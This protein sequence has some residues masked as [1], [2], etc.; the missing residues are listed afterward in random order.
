VSCGGLGWIRAIPK[1]R[2]DRRIGDLSAQHLQA[3]EN[4]LR[5]VL[6]LEWLDNG[7]GK[8]EL[9]FAGGAAD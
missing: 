8:A 2:L 7:T 3:V 9:R 6:E 5:Q 1:V 4:G